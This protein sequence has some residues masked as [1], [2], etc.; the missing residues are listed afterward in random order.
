M[1]EFKG[2]D[3]WI[4]IFKGGKQTDSQGREH[5]GNALIDKAVSQF[6]AARHEPPVVIGHPAENAPAWGWVEG[7]KKQGDLLMAKIK[8]VHPDFAAMVASAQFKKRSAAFYPDGSLRHVGFLGAMP[9]A[10]KGLP[11]VAFAEFAEGD[12]ATFE[13]ADDWKMNA[14]S[15][16]FRRLR[17]WL[18]DKFDADTADRIVPNW[19]IE[20]IKQAPP[21]DVA[22][23]SLTN[24]AEKEDKNMTWKEFSQKFLDLA[25]GLDAQAAPAPAPPGQT[26]TEADL[27]AIRKQAADAAAKEEREKVAAEF[28]EKDRLA[29]SEGRK[30]EIAAWCDSMVA[31]GKLTP[32]MVKYGVPDLLTAFAE[33]EDVIEFGEGDQATLFDRFKGLFET[34]LPQMIEFKEI[35]TRDKDTGGKG[36]AGAKL[37]ALT[38]EKMKANKDLSYVLAF[39]EVQIEHPDLAREY[40]QEIGG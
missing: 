30:R 38:A 39:T 24:Y 28:A 11:D 29:R 12:A 20:D 7:L 15:D 25:S 3:D 35:A 5:D 18:I 1:Y 27:E 13:F 40:R 32:A 17:E 9:P 33:K 36:G 31:Q 6:N 10:V 2:F 4:P 23:P 22:V 8:Q 16:V 14:V 34:Q 21:E 19:T 37:T 26:F